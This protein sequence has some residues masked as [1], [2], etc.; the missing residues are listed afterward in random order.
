MLSYTGNQELSCLNLH[1]KPHALE[2]ADVC[3]RQ[4][5]HRILGFNSSED[6][7]A[8]RESKMLRRSTDEEKAGVVD[9]VLH[10]AATPKRC[11]SE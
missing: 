1:R 2:H 9:I 8:D 3:Q 10:L 11:R 5:P 7:D 4:Y 6:A